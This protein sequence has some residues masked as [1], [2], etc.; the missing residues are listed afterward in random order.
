MKCEVGSQNSIQRFPSVIYSGYSSHLLNTCTVPLLGELFKWTTSCWIIGRRTEQT[1]Q[2]KWMFYHWAILQTL[3]GKHTDDYNTVWLALWEMQ[4]WMHTQERR[5][6]LTWGS[7]YLPGDRSRVEPWRITR[8]HS[9]QKTEAQKSPTCLLWVKTEVT[10]PLFAFL[11]I[12]FHEKKSHPPVYVS[13]FTAHDFTQLW[14]KSDEP[15]K[16]LYLLLHREV[17]QILSHKGEDKGLTK[18]LTIPIIS[19]SRAL[20]YNIRLKALEKKSFRRGLV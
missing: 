20:T 8:S 6:A 10:G 3:K 15:Q 2:A 18:D 7:K 13:R 4:R 14:Q 16:L 17:C 19:A 12:K 9:T 5:L 11:L 1:M